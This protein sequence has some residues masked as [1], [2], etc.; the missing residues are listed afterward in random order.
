MGHK[1]IPFSVK[2]TRYSPRDYSFTHRFFWFLYDLDFPES[3]PSRY[4]S[5]NKFN[6]YSYFDSDHMDIGGKTARE[7]FILFAEQNGLDTEV[8][9]VQ[10]LTQLRFLGYVF[11]PVSFVILTD[12]R[13]KKHFIIEIGN[14]FNELK[15]FYVHNK[16]LKNNILSFKTTKNFYI[17]PFIAHDSE[18]DFKIKLTDKK[19]VMHVNDTTQDE[20]I[21][22][23]WVNGDIQD[24]SSS[25][26]LKETLY[27]PFSTF[28]I[29]FLIHWHALV[30]WLMGIRFYKK[31]EFKELQ[32]G[33]LIWKKQ[34]TK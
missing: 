19:V 23:V 5:K 22:K 3:W 17:S 4:V 12:V 2:H 8:R 10:I 21:L 34:K 30:L 9:S 14:T 6:L 20:S 31:G 15:P 13:D 16:N 26:L 28:K 29:I 27:I 25:R 1:I 11:N 32:Q 18:L 33:T 24:A 7:N